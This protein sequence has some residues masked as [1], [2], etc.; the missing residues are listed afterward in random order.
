ME[1]VKRSLKVVIYVQNRSNVTTS[2]AVVGGR[3]NSNQVL[4]FEPIFKSIHNQLVGSG[5]KVKVV[6][7]VELWG[8][9][10]SKEPSCSSRTHGP[11]F[12]IFRI[13]PHKVAEWSFMGDF[14]SSFN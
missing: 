7:V 8:N 6:Q 13:T 10:G 14:H 5:N 4:V 2:V 12:N 1:D 9:L 11:K 3:P